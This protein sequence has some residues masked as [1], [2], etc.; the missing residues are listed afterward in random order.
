[1]QV[2]V[3]Q[4]IMF[5]CLLLILHKTALLLV[6]R[7]ESGEGESGNRAPHSNLT[8]GQKLNRTAVTTGLGA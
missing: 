4:N 8:T 7:A 5:V 6:N 2:D 1:M 3:K